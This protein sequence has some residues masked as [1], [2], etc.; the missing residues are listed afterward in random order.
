MFGCIVAS[1]GPILS[2]GCANIV[3]VCALLD[4][5]T[6]A[7]ALVWLYLIS[8]QPPSFIGRNAWSPGTSACT[9]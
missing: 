7:G 4:G 9:L 2:T 1:A 6:Q 5:A 8:G 3:R